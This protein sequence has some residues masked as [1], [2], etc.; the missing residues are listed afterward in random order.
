MSLKDTEE[1]L[2]NPN[3]D[4]EKRE[5]A[6]SEFDLIGGV[7]Q[8]VFVEKKTW[9]ETFR[10]KWLDED[11]RMAIYVGAI[12]L[13]AIVLFSLIYVGVVK[14][15]STAFS[16]N[17][18]TVAVE[19]P[20]E[21]DSAQEAKYVIK[22]KNGN[23]VSLEDVEINFNHSEN[24]YPQANKDIK[25]ESDRNI[26]INI[27]KV[28]AFSGGEIEIVGKFYAAE[29]YVVYLQPTIRYK[30][31][32]FNSFFEA[33]SQ[34]GVRIADSPIELTIKTPK[35]AIDESTIE[36]EVGYENKG[37]VDLNN[38]N[39]RLEYSDGVI[40]QDGTPRP[41]GGD[42]LWYLGNLSKGAKGSI[43]IK[44]KVDGQQYDTKLIKA[45]I[46][47]N[48]NNKSEIVY[49]K[50]ESVIKIV[51]P[52]LAIDLKINGKNSLNANVG[53]D[54]AFVITY[55][56]RG[57]IGLKDVIVKLKIDSPIIEYE[58]IN[59]SEGSYD[60]A[61]KSFI[62]K[63]SDDRELKRLEP[64]NNGQIN[65]DIPIKEKIDIKSGEDKNFVI[66]AVA[67]IDSSDVAYHSLG[68][69]KNISSTVLA[70]LNSKVIFENLLKYEDNDIKNYGPDP[71]VVGQETTN[72]VVWKITN[73]TN[74]ISNVKVHAII[75]TWVKWKGLV[76][77][78]GE[79]IAFNERTN[80]VIWNIGN[81]E[82]G[83]GILNSAREVKFQ[84]GVTP[85]VNQTNN[86]LIINQAITVTG[87]D[88]FTG[89]NI[90]L[91]IN[92]Q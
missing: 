83:K 55:A 76:F 26:K 69:S 30:A 56:N 90:E 3:S 81:I 64:G 54:L 44:S 42:N 75:P 28:R 80:E 74:N 50:S 20:D 14:F 92:G 18:V 49:G 58:R 72:A 19:G 17:R 9:W 43:K 10:N 29:N 38:L 8:D 91:V 46:F 41:V 51:V 7:N 84:I 22:Y 57:D 16:E 62:W 4:I 1:Q 5:H 60:S 36:Y 6:K 79:D 73:L 65:I 35:E 71:W 52:P 34:F 82:S 67:T 63:V 37:G 86:D 40:F 45:S 23:R 21:I 11:K 48:E 88:D 25:I 2:Y 66:E 39:L 27:G 24:F 78:Q 89:E 47:K 85:G 59:F 31:Q 13:G 61:S 70:K 53:D 32:N 12:V 77:P 87:K 15:K 68:N 33:S